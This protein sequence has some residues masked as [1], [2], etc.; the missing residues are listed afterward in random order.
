MYFFLQ[1]KREE[2]KFEMEDQVAIQKTM[3]SL[4]IGKIIL[5]KDIRKLGWYHVKMIALVEDVKTIS[6]Q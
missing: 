4:F 1:T 5:L 3:T 2:A 6:V